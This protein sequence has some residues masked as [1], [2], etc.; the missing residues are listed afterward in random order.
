MFLITQRLLIIDVNNDIEFFQVYDEA[1]KIIP[2]TA[3]NKQWYRS[4]RRTFC[5]NRC[6][7]RRYIIPLYKTTLKSF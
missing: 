2:D 5:G 3:F 4:P 6:G 7:V 1:I